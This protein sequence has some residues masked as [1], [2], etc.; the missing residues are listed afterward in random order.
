[1]YQHPY[2]LDLPE[3]YPQT[4]LTGISEVQS[5]QSGDSVIFFYSQ[6]CVGILSFGQVS[7]PS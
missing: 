7:P 3:G 1:M 4:L 2:L 6:D 5:T